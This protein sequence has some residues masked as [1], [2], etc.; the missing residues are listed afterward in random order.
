MI[1]AANW[2]MH[3]SPKTA[4]DYFRS[5]NQ[6]CSSAKPSSHQSVFFVPAYNWHVAAQSGHDWGIQNFYPEDSGPFTGENSPLIAKEMGATWALIGHS[7]RRQIFG[8]DGNLINKKVHKAIQLGLK[9]LICIGETLDERK[10]GNIATALQQQLREALLNVNSNI[11]IYVAYEPIWAIGTGLTASS[12]E[13][14][15]THELIQKTLEDLGFSKMTPIL[16]GGSVK[17]ENS[18]EILAIKNVS[19]LLVGGA[20]LIPDSFFRI[21]Q[22][23]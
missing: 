2:K 22:S 12:N 10:S 20:S 11:N 16:Y 17:P 3:L 9:P 4:A 7:E 5:W 14:M 19:G 23:R 18:A 13:I 1:I 6:L 8:E 21:Y 15:N